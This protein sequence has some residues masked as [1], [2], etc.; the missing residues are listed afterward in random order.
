[1]FDFNSNNLTESFEKTRVT[2][3]D[4]RNVNNPR[5]VRKMDYFVPSSDLFDLLPRLFSVYYST[6]T[7]P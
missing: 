6:L 1:M 3:V 5:Q 7:I 4:M 2:D